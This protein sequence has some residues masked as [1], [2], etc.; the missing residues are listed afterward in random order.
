MSLPIRGHLAAL[1]TVFIWG[2][3]FVSTKVLLTGIPPVEILVYRFV[4]GYLALWVMAPR[5]LPRHA[6]REE[7]Y[8]AAAGL[9]GVSLYF[10]LENIALM[11]S[12]ASNVCIIVSTAPLFIALLA[13]LFT[14]G[15]ET[16]PRRFYL[17]FVVALS[18]IVIITLSGSELSF[19]PIGDF[20]AL[21]AAVVWAVYSHLLRRIFSFGDSM[22][23]STRR[24]FAY[25]I[26]FMIPAL[27]WEGGAAH[28]AAV[29]DFVYLGNLLFL[30][31]G[32][33]AGC[34]A[35]WSYAVKI[36]GPVKT[37]AYIYA[38][39]VITAVLAVFILN[40]PVTVLSACGMGLTILGLILSQ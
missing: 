15:A 4:I 10:L 3:T 8:F 19:S 1:I 6:W 13:P 2:A 17:G 21:A 35:L 33:S 18:G 5:R 12:M 14:R 36:M 16:A 9:T 11:Y 27:L 38:Q 34:F 28:L 26:L 31:L 25:G 20:L 39:P 7:A 22:L 29:T 40:E 23:L 32:A 37:G 30:G 24:I